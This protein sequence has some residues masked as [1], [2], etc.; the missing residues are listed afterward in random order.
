MIDKI[1]KDIKGLFKVQDKAKLLKQNIPYL[2]FFYVGNIFSHHVR[3]YTGGDVIDK[4]FQ[5]IL[6]L[7]TMSFIPSIH[8]SDILMGVGVV[9]LIKFIVYTKGKNAKK[10]RQG[11]EYGS[12]RWGTRKDIEPYVDEKFQNN[13][14]L[15]QTERLTMN[16]RPANPKYARNKNV[17]VI[18]GSGSGKT[19]FYV[20]PNL[21]QMHSSYC[22]TDPKGTIVIECGKMLEDNGYEIKILNTINFKK[23]MKYNPFAYLRSE[24][25][26]LKLV[27]TI[28]ANT[29]GEG[30]KAGEDF[31]VKAEKLY[32]TALIGY[33]F[34]EAPR[35]E[36]NFAT[37][38]DMIDASEVREDDETYMNPIDRLFEAL[39]KKEPTHFAVKQYKKY[40]LAAGKTAKSILISC[41]ARLAPFDIQELRDLMKE[42]ELELDTLGD[43]KTALFVIISDTDDTFNFVVSIMYS[44]LFNLL[45]D[46]ADDEYGGRLPVHVR[47]LLDEFANIGLIP[48]FEKLIA[49]IRSR[50]ISASIILQ[51][52]SQLKAIYKDNADTI[53]GNCDSTLF[54]GGKE[55][56]TLKELSETLGKETIDLYNTSETR[57]NAN[58][59]GLNYQK[60][61]KELMSQDEITVMDGSKCIF[62]LRGVRPFL[63]D[64]FDIT[65]HKNYKLL[66]DYDKKNVFDIEEYIK[67]KGKAKLNRE[68]VITRVQ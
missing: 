26:I 67:R 22:V 14:L 41:G 11:K 29:K 55:K 3:A 40:K 54:L 60:T 33:I 32:Y 12:A 50:E 53:V 42:D 25:D 2:A 38:L 66:E 43:R 49:T 45:C 27:Q 23:S 21:M 24:K 18:G 19:R 65:K 51:A 5:G 36:K 59:Y 37:L 62:Q 4:I 35:E 16:G 68:T 28:I 1:L 17:L 52:Q 8:P 48:K 57:S 10:F 47:C 58:S 7:N 46:K 34:Y 30:E 39:E 6:E 63:S 20:K 61:G 13:I 15:T 64:K 44:Q 9:A 56:T 31:W